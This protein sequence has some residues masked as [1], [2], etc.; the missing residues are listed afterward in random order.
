[1]AKTIPAKIP[2]ILVDA[3]KL[4]GNEFADDIKKK[5]HLKEL[6]VPNTLA[7][8]LIAG[9]IMS[10]KRFPVKIHKTSHDTAILELL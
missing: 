2:L 7:M 4:V 9:K 5:Y 10:G 6:F 8:E 1:M 3:C